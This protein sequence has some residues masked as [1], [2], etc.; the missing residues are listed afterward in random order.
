MTVC[1]KDDKL[2]RKLNRDVPL[3]GTVNSR[4]LEHGLRMI[5]AGVPFSRPFESI[6]IR[7]FLLLGVYSIRV[8]GWWVVAR[9][10][11]GRMIRGL[12]GGLNNPEGSFSHGQFREYYIVIF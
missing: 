8:Q 2:S 10:R 1:K 3:R 12:W 9:G 6:W 5:G 4:K 11:G 7:M